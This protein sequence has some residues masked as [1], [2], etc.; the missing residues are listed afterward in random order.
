MLILL[1]FRL[2]AKVGFRLF[3]NL[4]YTTA[5]DLNFKLKEKKNFLQNIILTESLPMLNPLS[6]NFFYSSSINIYLISH[7][8]KIAEGHTDVS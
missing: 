6:N 4:W 1:S 8:G 5:M 3:Y 2:F 7:K